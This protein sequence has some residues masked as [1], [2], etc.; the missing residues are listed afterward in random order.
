MEGGVGAPAPVAWLAVRAWEF[1][2]ASDTKLLWNKPKKKQQ[3]ANSDRIAVLNP[4]PKRGIVECICC[5]GCSKT[6][7]THYG[8]LHYILLI[9]Y[10]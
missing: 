8:G 6:K 2:I 10:K 7:V 3:T 1:S 5:T 9:T 4:N